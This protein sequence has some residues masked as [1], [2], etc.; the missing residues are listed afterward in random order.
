LEGKPITIYGDGSQVRAFTF[1]DDI[2]PA[3]WAAATLPKAAGQTFNVGEL[4]PWPILHA[5]E[6]FCQ[7]APGPVDRLPARLEVHAAWCGT[8]RARAVLG[9]ETPTGLREGLRAM[10]AWAQ[11]N[12]PE[13]REQVAP[14]EIKNPSRP[15]DAGA[16]RAVA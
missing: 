13:R 6:A 11:E 14:V 9:L 1:I 7:A 5:A 4:T 8:S 15:L 12:H 16:G 3:V 10:W 2:L